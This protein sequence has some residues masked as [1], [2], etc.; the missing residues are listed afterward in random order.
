MNIINYVKEHSDDDFKTLPFTE[1]DNLILSLLPYL[2]FTNIVAPFKGKKITLKEAALKLK[3]KDYEYRGLFNHNTYKLLQIMAN[4]KRYGDALLFNYMRVVNKEMQFGAL[5]IVLNDNTKYISY[6]G[7]DTSIIGWE[8]DFKM[9]YMYPG[10]SQKYATVYLNKAVKLLDK[11]ILVGGHSKGGNLA[12]SAAMN[13][14]FY[15]RR[16]I[17]NIY[18]NDGPGF[19]KEQV[20]SNLYKK[21]KDKIKMYV[22]PE[23]IIGMLLYHQEEYI[24]VKSRGFNIIQHDA[25]NWLCNNKEFIRDT[26]NKRSKN[27]E[28]KLTKKLEELPIE[29]RINLVKNIFD[30]FKNNGINDFKE[31][32]LKNFWLIIKSFKGLDK[33]A[34]NILGELLLILFIK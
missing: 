21:I 19:L 14:K 20:E 9:A 10:A 24:V 18:N 12:I 1:V 32:D 11:N 26:Q 15:I 5:T 3:E 2:D 27:L 30:I 28:F 31:I 16:K 29:K 4:T 25:F 7:T 23:S 6:A 17:K 33:E 22:P 34:Q 8:E 13:T